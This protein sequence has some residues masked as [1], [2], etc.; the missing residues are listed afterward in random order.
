MAGLSL[1]KYC[2]AFSSMISTGLLF[3]SLISSLSPFNAVTVP[4]M[5]SPWACE[6]AAHKTR[7]NRQ[8]ATRFN[9]GSSPCLVMTFMRVL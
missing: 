7:V 8:K 3:L 6:S 2:V 5:G 9:I 4:I 1:M